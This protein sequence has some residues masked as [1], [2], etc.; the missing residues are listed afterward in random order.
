MAGLIVSGLVG[1]TALVHSQTVAPSSQNSKALIVDAAKPGST[2]ANSGYIPL[3]KGTLNFNKHIA[4]IIYDNC[5]SCHR[6][7][8]VAPFSLLTY[9]DVQK[10]A[11]QIAL[12]T[13]DHTMPPWKADA[14]H[15]Q[16]L[17]ARLLSQQQ[18]GMIQQWA[19]EGAPEGKA[20]D[21]PPLPKFASGWKLGQPDAIFEPDEP[22]HVAADGADVY[23]CFVIPTNYTEDRWVSAVEVHPD[24]R[25]IVH[26]VIAFLDKTGQ[27][28]KLDAA[29]PGPGYTSTGG[30]IGFSP[31]S[32]GLGGWAPGNEPRLLPAGL[33]IYLP[34]GTDIVLQVHYHK[35]G[36]PET[37]RTKIGLYFSK[38][39]VDK[40][41]RTVPMLYLPLRIPAGDKQYVVHTDMKAPADIT[42]QGIMPHMHL[43]G[44]EMTVTAT[45]PN[46]ATRKLVHVPDW[47][48]NWQ[49][50]Y[51]FK[52]P[53]PLPVGSKLE[54]SAR[55]DNSAENPVNPHNP[56][57][58]VRWGEET[59]NE[60]CI[61]FVYYTVDA[62]HLIQGKVGPGFGEGFGAAAFAGNPQG[63]LRQLTQMF[64][65]NGDGHLD[66][67]ERAAMGEFIRSNG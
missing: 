15:E 38:T 18:I 35:S 42:V 4:P 13:A 52:E 60:M 45:P 48:F 1:L 49:T 11:R 51:A 2:T 56:P 61:A 17:D 62:E 40:R 8:E 14:G 5:A 25:K 41:V 57:Q 21:L 28:R 30:G 54:L 26:H 6:P 32:G 24:N 16:F 9:Q 7:G 44:R 19:A 12:V 22:Y 59:T 66:D 31:K 65:K 33:G 43:L 3:P 36:K 29:D 47:D 46:G 23:R 55:Y 67:E 37:D 27:A 10:R 39:P 50:T 64:D 20:A 63:L 58:E 34:K 53:V